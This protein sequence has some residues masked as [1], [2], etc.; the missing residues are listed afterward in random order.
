M[1]VDPAQITP[2]IDAVGALIRTRT[3][4]RHGRELG[5]FTDQT[6]PTDSEVGPLLDRAAR[7]VSIAV[8]ERFA[9]WT[10]ALLATARDAVASFAALYVE[11][12]YYADAS[13]RDQEQPADQLGRIAREQLRAL[14]R[15]AGRGRL[16]RSIQLESW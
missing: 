1:P 5:T 16:G 2:E 8:G 7:Y 13:S 15:D 10:P 11:Q 3:I 4:D 6:R 14:Q 9:D 12:S